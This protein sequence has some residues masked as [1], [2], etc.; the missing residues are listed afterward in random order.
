ME[1]HDICWSLKRAEFKEGVKIPSEKDFF[2]KECFTPDCG[3]IIIKIIIFES[4]D[5][6]PK[7][8]EDKKLN[9]KIELEELM[10]KNAEK[11]RKEKEALEYRQKLS[12]ERIKKKSKKKKTERNVDS[13][14]K[15]MSRD[16]PPPKIESLIPDNCPD[17]SNI[18]P[19][20][21]VP[22]ENMRKTPMMIKRT[23][24]MWT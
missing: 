5:G 6:D 24:V 11:S 13:S 1:F 10:K 22:L 23:K 17:L 12:E 18:A 19:E 9:E 2:G 16:D 4:C 14:E 8:I 21:P 7:I 15:E 3:S 20:I